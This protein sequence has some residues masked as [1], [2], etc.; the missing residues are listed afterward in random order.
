MPRPAGQPTSCSMV[1]NNSSND[2]PVMTSGIT[3]GAVVVALQ[4]RGVPLGQA[5]T[6]GLAFHAVETAAG[7]SFGTASALLLTRFPRRA[8][9]MAGAGAAACLTAAFCATV[10]LPLA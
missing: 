6:T 7:I 9:A 5:V 3:S 4:A 1:T 8:L 10:V 2:R